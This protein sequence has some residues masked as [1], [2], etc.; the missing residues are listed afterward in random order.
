MPVR[1]I[2]LDAAGTLLQLTRPVGETYAGL[3]KEFAIEI[4]ADQID[5]QFRILF[6]KMPALA[7]GRCTATE[8][9]RQER[10]WWQTLV[11]N[12]LGA[13]SRH[14][15][16]NAFFNHIYD[17]YA[18]TQAWCL[19]PEITAALDQLTTMG[20]PLSVVSNFDS[21]LDGLLDSLRIR[22]YF[23]QVH[24]SSLSGYAKPRAEIFTL[25][26]AALNCPA[27]H[28]LHVGDNYKS[29][30]LG[31]RQAGLQACLLQRDKSA[32]EPH[33]IDTLM[34]LAQRI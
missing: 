31:A 5:R 7:F 33:V 15:N 24:Y 11:G 12:C 29:D 19:Y 27:G 28:T 34:A 26:C 14:K 32:D 4:E 16:F 2:T 20:L 13:Q 21:R 17:Y 18:S 25:A 8:R 9:Q 6:P 10:H 3:G 1:A 23:R 30:Y 22:S